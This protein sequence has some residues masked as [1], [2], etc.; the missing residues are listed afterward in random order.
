MRSGVPFSLAFSEV[1]HYTFGFATRDLAEKGFYANPRAGGYRYP[2]HVPLVW[3]TPV[4]NAPG[5]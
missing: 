3:T 2:G 5:Q 1:W 4:V